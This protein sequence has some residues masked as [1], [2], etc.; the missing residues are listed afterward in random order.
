MK[1]SPAPWTFDPDIGGCRT[2]HCNKRIK[3]HTGEDTEVCTTPG[4]ADDTED[5]ANACLIAAAP[6][7]L[8]ALKSIA[9]LLGQGNALDTKHDGEW[10][11]NVI[12]SAEPQP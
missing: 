6:D 11:N 2:I 1:H 9:I 8:S 3:A 7:M 5:Y 10:I 4:L 12:A